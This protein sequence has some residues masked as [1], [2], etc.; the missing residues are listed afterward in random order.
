VRASGTIPTNKVYLDLSG[1]SSPARSYTISTDNTTAIE[2]IFD[3]EADGE[4][5]WYDM[6][7]RRINKPTKAG[8]YIKN[9][10]KVVIKNK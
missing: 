6:Q 3:E 8:L 5:K 1:S 4:E 9:G 10:Q 7:G 2:G